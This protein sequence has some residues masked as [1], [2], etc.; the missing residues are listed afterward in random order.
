MVR[1]GI[2]PSNVTAILRQDD[3]AATMES[4]YDSEVEL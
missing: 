1:E 2:A 4:I 3:I